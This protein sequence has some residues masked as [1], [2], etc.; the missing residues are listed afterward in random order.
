MFL[1]KGV[2]VVTIFLLGV[3]KGFAQKDLLYSISSDMAVNQAA[4][5]FKIYSASRV[6]S[7]P[8]IDGILDDLCWKT[9]VWDDSF[10]QQQPQ[11]AHA[12]SQ[13]TSIA[14]AYDDDNLYV[15][16]KCF[17]SNIEGVRSILSRRDE[18]NGDMVGI[19]LDSYADDRTAFEFNVTA[20]GQK[21]DMMHLGQDEVDFNWD[22]IWDAATSINDTMW[23]AELRIPFSQLRFAKAEEQVW[24]LHAWRYIDRLGEED[25][26]KLI[27]VD[28]PATVYLFGDV[29]N[30]RNINTKRK[31]ELLPYGNLK[32]SP[33]TELKNEWKAGAGIDG[34]VGLSSD[35]TLDFTVNPDFGQVE[36]DPS[37][38]SLK[39]YE[40]FYDEKRPF[41]LEG[42]NVLGFNSGSDQLFYSRRIGHAPSFEPDTEPGQLSMPENTSIIS[43][44]KVTGKTKRGLSVGFLHSMTAKESATV[45]GDD[46]DQKITVEPFSNYF[47]GRVKQDF[48]K[49]NTVLGGMLTSV[50]RNISD[51]HLSFLPKSSLTGGIDFLHSWN[52]RKYYVKMKGF[53]SDVRGSEDAISDLQRASQHYYQRPDASHLEYDPTR[54]SLSGHGGEFEGGLHNGKIRATGNFS[55]RSPGVDLNDVGYIYQADYLKESGTLYY[56]MS[57]PWWITRSYWFR[58]NQEANWSYGGEKTSQEIGSH[59][60]LYFRNLWK[61]H[62][63]MKRVYN[64]YDT[65]ELRGGP[66]LFKEP[67]WE[68]E[69]FCQTNASKDFFVGFQKRWVVGDDN[70][71]HRNLNVLNLIFRLGNNFSFSTNAIYVENSDY[72][73]YAGAVKFSDGNRGYV[74]GQIDQKVLQSTVRL[75]YFLTPELSLQYYA[76]P[77]ASIG[78]YSEFRRVLD[79]SN[80]DINQRYLNL[81]GSLDGGF[82][83]FTEGS[84]TYSMRNPDFTFKEFNSNLVARWEFRPGSTL[85]FVWNNT[86]S[87]YMPEYNSSVTKVFRDIPGT[88]SQNLFMLKFTYWFTL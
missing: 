50:A 52:K 33:N 73:Q 24:G 44:A 23:I 83:D 67:S 16:I 19:A 72:H 38:L 17:D 1:Q 71:S 45:Y 58:I 32:Y 30:I 48:N 54:T 8:R 77:Y 4:S 39:S 76:S 37:I 15:G 2:L 47:V 5:L 43:A 6:D 35:F 53:Y 69:V 20:A 7:R 29:D 63:N 75:E 85:Y 46:A 81:Q 79:G 74:V 27:P 82:Y 61:V 62:L 18:Y 88:S 36:A 22:A 26:W 65:R 70:I 51:E 21:I 10:I 31:L 64:V 57:K 84:E 60:Y 13:K 56:M 55:W 66:S 11:E 78:K 3:C 28:A 40:I 14:L 87:D 9:A 59:A 80:K 34:K 68:A 86:I 42:N 25:H 41:F 12:P 49:G